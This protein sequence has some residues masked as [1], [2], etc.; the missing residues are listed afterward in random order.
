MIPDLARLDAGFVEYFRETGRWQL[1]SEALE[2]DGL[3][4]VAGTRRFAGMVN[5][6]ARLDPALSPE[7]VLGRAREFF[8]ARQRGFSLYVRGEPDRDLEEYALAEGAFAPSEG[9]PWMVLRQR[10]AETPHVPGIRLDAVTDA[11]GLEAVRAVSREAYL[12]SGLPHEVTDSALANESAIRAPHIRFF[13]AWDGDAP[14]ATAACHLHAGV[15]GIYWVG[16]RDAARR[17]GL[18]TLVTHAAVHWGFDQ[19]ADLSALQASE[20]GFP[21]YQAMGFETFATT[22]LL[23][24]A[25]PE[26]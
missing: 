24:V 12:P 1:G 15:A 7:S 9:G 18:G 25:G 17:R 16:T 3:L 6:A 13:V 5:L 20:M 19:G 22:R 26:R 11:R 23:I 21:I 8:H 4:L 14:L 10:P 2:K